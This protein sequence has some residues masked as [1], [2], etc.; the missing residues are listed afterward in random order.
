MRLILIAVT[1]L[2]LAG[3]ASAADPAAARAHEAE[4]D[5]LRAQGQYA[6]ALAEYRAE[7][8]AGGQTAEA[9]KRI[10]WSLRALQRTPEAAEALRKATELDPGDREA[11]DDLASLRRSRGLMVRAWLGGTEPGT[12]KQALEGQLRYAGFDRLELQAGGGWTDNIFYTATKAYATAYHF[13][14]AGSYLKGDLSVRRY[15]YSGA[16][17]PTPDS[18]AY[19]LVPRLEV[20]VS[21]R[22][23]RVLRGALAYQLFAPDFFYDQATRIVNHKVSAEVELQ[24]GRGFSVTGMAAL[25]RDPDPSR[26]T[27]KDRRLPTVPPGTVTCGPGIVSPDCATTTSVVMRTEVLVGGGAAYRAEPITA[28]VRFIPNRDLDSGYAWSVLSW[29]ELRPRERLSFDL[30][31]ILDRYSS[32][33][34][35]IFAGN[36]GNIYWGRARY[37]LTPALALGGGLKF[38]KNPSP[39]STSPT[40]GARGDA[41]LLLDVEWRTG[42]LHQEAGR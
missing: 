21:H 1:A 34:G 16:N 26:T 30:Q 4:G 9:W 24:L 12:S 38:V 25:L 20:E 32:V 23:G 19:D 33:S 13:Y 8:A 42:L 35:P 11:R 22:F 6:A 31:W 14:G 17:R 18:N 40:A 7:V 41:T 28:S 15:A 27:I 3:S 10:G 2:L 5:R 36:Y 37:Q 29:L 39:A